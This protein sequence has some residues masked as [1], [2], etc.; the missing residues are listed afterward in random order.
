MAIR[1]INAVND[2]LRRARHD[3]DEGSA[4]LRDSEE[5]L[6]TAAEAAQFGA[7]EYDVVH[8]RTRRSPQF[9]KILG[10]DDADAWR[11]SRPASTSSIPTIAT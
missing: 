2:A 4:A 5:R 3:L 8:D 1:E 9:L 10:A 6:R 11:R 7:H